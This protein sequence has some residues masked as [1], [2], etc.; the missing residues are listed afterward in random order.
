MKK[1]EF[2]VGLA[3]RDIR[4]QKSLKDSG[5]TNDYLMPDF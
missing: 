2:L 1:R 3:R 5:G 4:D